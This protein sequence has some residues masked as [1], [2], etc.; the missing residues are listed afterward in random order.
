MP[1]YQIRTLDSGGTSLANH[2]I[3]CSG[4]DEALAVAK[5]LISDGGLAHVSAGPRSVDEVF[6][7]LSEQCDAADIGATMA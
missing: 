6:V 7:P 4:D 2:V 5:D 1:D 3:H